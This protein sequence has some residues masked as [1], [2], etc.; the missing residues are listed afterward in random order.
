MAQ[1]KLRSVSFSYP[2]YSLANR[3]LKAALIENGVGAKLITSDNHFRAHALAN[4][5]LSLGRGDRLG[6]IGRNGSGKS[7]LLKLL[8]GVLGPDSGEIEVSGRVVPLLSR[9]VGLN[10]ERTGRQNIELPLRLLGATD[11]EIRRAWL[12][13]PDWTGLGAYMDMPVRTYSDGM[14]SRLVFALSTAIDGDILVLDEWLGAGDADF[15]EKARERLKVLVNRAGIVVLC[16][17]SMRI[18][19]Q[20]CSVVCWLDQGRVV[21]IGNPKEV[22]AAYT[23]STVVASALDHPEAQLAAE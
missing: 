14:R 6:I 22:I 19:E 5:T 23:G 9:G 15:V 13:V 17:H 4:V 8:A 12:D 21:M 7:T 10:P 18:I 2:V 11:D 1:L 3:S 20:I 16:S